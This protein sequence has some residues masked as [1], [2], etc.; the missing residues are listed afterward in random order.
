G[1]QE[2]ALRAVARE[3]GVAGRV[4]FTG[5]RP[6]EPDGTA[7]PDLPSLACAM[8]VLASPS[9]Q[10]AFGLAVV[11][12]LACGLPVLYASCPA[13]EDLPAS[14]APSAR[15]V[16]GGPGAFARALA[17]VREGAPPSR[18]AP[19][20]ARHYC[21]TRT[22]G[23]L[24]DVYAAA[25]AGAAPPPSP[26]APAPPAPSPAP[27]P[28]S[29]SSSPSPQA[30]SSAW[31]RTPRRRRPRRR[32]PRPHRCRRRRPRHPRES[33]PHDREPHRAAPPGR[34]PVPAPGPAA[35]VAARGRCP[36][37]RGARHHLRAGRHAH[38]HGHQLCRGGAEGELRPGHR[39]RVRPGV[40]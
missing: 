3:A 31:P 38:L 26:P 15:R 21:V 11:E 6:G 24:T 7:G 19:E 2:S 32:R 29:P 36:R 34:R 37:R 20:A 14:A 27:P 16:D 4:L 22:A 1:E 23:L 10:E 18:E 35:L 33:V 8:D 30:A 9:P 28:L 39:P 25:L 17:R 40:R 5:E 13:L 12:A